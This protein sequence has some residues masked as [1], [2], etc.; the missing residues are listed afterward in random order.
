VDAETTAL[1]RA[2]IRELLE[3]HDGDIATRLDEFGFSDVVDEEPAVAIDL[4]FS[5]QGAAGK[6][7][8]ALDAVALAGMPTA[9]RRIVHPIAAATAGSRNGA[10]IHIDGVLLGPAEGSAV[11][12]VGDA[13]FEIPAA[14]VA[15]VASSVEGFDQASNL[16]RVRTAIA[17]DAAIPVDG[18]WTPTAIIFRAL[19]AELV[20]NGTAMLKIAAEQITERKQFGRPIG[21]NQT[22]R[23]R[24]AESYALLGGA[25][26]L[27]QAAW[28]SGTPWDARVAKAYAGY[29]AHTTSRACL[30]VCGAIGLTTE[31]RL[32]VY[33]K[34]G[35]LLD[36]LYGGWQHSIDA[37]GAQLLADA[38]VPTAARI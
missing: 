25:A 20:G 34:R 21:A 35:R 33:V 15:S 38:D 1:L 37:L 30:Q 27:V 19:A 29:A 36:A 5:E 16:Y 24:L 17:V 23:H 26:E 18:N 12:D 8:S 31:H 2:S 9:V 32:P 3:T 6:S 10:K 4:L 28:R 22:P 7:S 14:N 13:V 11:V